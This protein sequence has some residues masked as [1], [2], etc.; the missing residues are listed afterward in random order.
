MREVRG[1][2]R[3][4]AGVSARAQRVAFDAE[5]EMPTK[6][7]VLGLLPRLPRD[8]AVRRAARVEAG[9]VPR[10][11]TIGKR[12]VYALLIDPLPDPLVDGRAWRLKRPLDLAAMRREAASCVGTHDFAAFRS[13]ADERA[14]TTRTMRSLSVEPDE[15]DP[16]VLC[17]TVE[18]DHFLHNMVRIL[19]GTFVD[20]GRGR[21]AEGACA[22]AIASGRRDD[23][24]I[25]APAEGLLLDEVLLDDGGADAY[26]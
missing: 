6:G 5:R 4:D 2:S 25:T 17:V 18:G 21:L 22:R 24:G 3:T 10:F 23:L 26:P 7:W 1:A 12:Y 9:F 16:R 20:V 11:R 8:V 15:V 13:S 19:V 14:S